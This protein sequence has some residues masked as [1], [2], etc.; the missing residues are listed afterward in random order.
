MENTE[1]KQFVY[2]I[3]NRTDGIPAGMYEHDTVE[4]AE[5]TIKKLREGYRKQGHYRTSRM[6]KIAPEDIQYEVIPVE[7][8]VEDEL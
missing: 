7:K 4:E 6:E 2:C 5:E 1:T 8:E 3:M